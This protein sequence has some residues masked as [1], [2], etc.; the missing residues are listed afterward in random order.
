MSLSIYSSTAST[1]LHSSIAPA[2]SSKP[3]T[4]RSEFLSKEICTYFRACGVRVVSWSM[5]LLAFANRL[6]SV[7]TSNIGPSATSSVIRFRSILVVFRYLLRVCSGCVS[8]VAVSR[9]QQTK[10]VPIRVRIKRSSYIPGTYIHAASGLFSCSMGLLAFASR[11]CSPTMLY[12]LLHLLFRS[13]LSW[14][15]LNFIRPGWNGWNGTRPFVVVR[16]IPS[17]LCPY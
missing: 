9:T 11:L 5:E 8:T 7:C 1:A 2:E 6:F 12:H 14:V 13:I 10:Y 15:C 17:C 4:C 16:S 3:S